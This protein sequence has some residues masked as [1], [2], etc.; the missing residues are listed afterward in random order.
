MNHCKALKNS[1]A[2]KGAF[3]NIVELISFQGVHYPAG[4]IFNNPSY[5]LFEN[6]EFYFQFTFLFHD[7]NDL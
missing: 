6:E 4:I 2:L 1:G 3:V 7:V 5:A